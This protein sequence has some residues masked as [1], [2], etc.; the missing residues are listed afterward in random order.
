MMK[1]V[2]FDLDGTLIDS[3]P[4]W[5]RSQ[6]TLVRSCG[7]EWS[8]ALADALQGAAFPETVRLLRGAGVDWDGD[9]IVRHLSDEVLRMEKEHLP[10]IE[11]VRD[12]LSGLAAAHVPAVLVTGSPR[13]IV[14]NVM[15]QAPKGAFVGYVCGNDDVTPKPDPAPYWRAASM[16]GLPADV[17]GAGQCLVFEDSKP[18]LTAAQASGATVVAVTGHARVDM[19]DSGLCDEAIV[20]YRGLTI[21]DLAGWM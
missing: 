6:E 10:W 12:V 1:A 18:G 2:F 14:E 13:E 5:A 11:G 4:Y 15:T 16:V 20:D 8:D 17:S 19:S 9:A 3:D 21:A 7:G